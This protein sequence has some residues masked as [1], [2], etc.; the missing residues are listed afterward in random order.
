MKRYLIL[1]LVFALLTTTIA[2]TAYASEVGTSKNV[3][4]AE[5]TLELACT[6]WPEH[7]ET[8]QVQAAKSESEIPMATLNDEKV[9]EKTYMLSSEETIGY[10]EYASGRS[11]VYTISKWYEDSYTEGNTYDTYRGSLNVVIGIQS[12][13]LMGFTYRIFHSDYDEIYRLGTFNMNDR[14]T[15]HNSYIKYIED[16]AGS[17]CYS[18]MAYFHTEEGFVLGT[19]LVTLNVGNDTFTW[20]VS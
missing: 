18:Y 7:K 16:S 8:I 3:R 13:Y 20:S 10:I 9:I 1:C 12:V 17:A 2:P 15:V 5:E 11:M 19:A 4:T 14:I 6:I